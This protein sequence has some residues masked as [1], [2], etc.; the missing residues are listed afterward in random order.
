MT[1]K[2]IVELFKR[3]ARF[4]EPLHE[5]QS[6]IIVELAEV[7]AC[8]HGNI[9]QDSFDTLVRIGA[10]MYR[11]GLDQFRAR[12]EVAAIMQHADQSNDAD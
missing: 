4:L 11:D 5:A 9:R 12:K 8:I 2:D 3:E 6:T 10:I 7:I 1:R